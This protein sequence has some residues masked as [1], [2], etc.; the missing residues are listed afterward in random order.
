MDPSAGIFTTETYIPVSA[1][2]DPDMTK[3]VIGGFRGKAKSSMETI[4]DIELWDK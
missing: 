2:F 1:S 3:P 4:V